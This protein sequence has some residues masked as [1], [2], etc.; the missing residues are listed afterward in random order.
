MVSCLNPRKILSMPFIHLPNTFKSVENTSIVGDL[1]N[2]IKSWL[3]DRNS[4]TQR[5]IEHCLT[6]KK[7]FNVNVL[8][9]QQQIPET[10]DANLLNMANNVTA[11]VR[12]VLLNCGETPVV[13]AKT[14]IPLTTLTGKQRELA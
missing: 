12:E 13:Y 11:Y 14:I 6:Q 8:K 4:L 9:Q 1:D 3:L 2:N 7:E 10:E 5:I